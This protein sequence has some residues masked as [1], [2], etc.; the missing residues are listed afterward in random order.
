MDALLV[1]PGDGGHLGRRDV[2]PEA[3]RGGGGSI[4]GRGELSRAREGRIE[5]S[6][7]MF[8]SLALYGL[9]AA[10]LPEHEPLAITIVGDE[11]NPHS[12]SDAELTQPRDIV[13]ALEAADSGISIGSLVA[14]ESGCI[15]DALA[16]MP[17]T[18]VF[19]YFAHRAATDCAGGDAQGALTDATRSLL[20][21]GGGVVVF[22]HGIYTADGKDEILRLL[23]GV[24]N[25]IEWLDNG[26]PAIAVAEGHFVT[27]NEVEYPDTT[28]FG[29]DDLGIAQADYPSFVNAPAEAYPGT[30]PQLDGSEDFTVLFTSTQPGAELLGYD[31][32]RPTWSGHTVFIQPGEYQPNALDDRDGNS[33]QILAN[34]IYYVGT[35]QDEPEPAPATTGGDDSSTGDGGGGSDTSDATATASGGGGGGASS[36]GGTASG[37]DTDDGASADDSDSAGCRVGGSSPWGLGLFGLLM[38]VRR[39]GA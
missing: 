14:V 38:L 1:Q 19:I 8:A 39:R 10:S 27:T 13:E 4:R 23:G 30:R 9:L 34:A 24:A 16:A 17:E 18:D 12:L 36:A 15:D 22:H 6:P 2:P 20:E 21:S 33:F 29:F 25:Q 7:S 37:G 35:T 11:V 32:R 26:R 31:L 28:P 3:N 5:Y